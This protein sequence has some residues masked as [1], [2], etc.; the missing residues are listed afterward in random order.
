[1]TATTALSAIPSGLR[2]PLLKEYREI[3]Q[4]YS[5]HRWRP[6]ELSGGHFSE[7]V[8]TILDGH[9]SGTYAIG[10]SKPSDFVTACRKLETNKHVPRSF[11]ILIPRMLPA[12]YEV[13]NQRS[14]GHTGGDVDPNHMDA[15]LVI[16]MSNWIMA[17][18]VRVFHQLPTTEQAQIIVDTLAERTVPLVWQSGHLKR[19][20]DPKMKLPDQVMLLIASAPGPLLISQVM[21][22]C[23]AKTT[24]QRKHFMKTVRRLHAEKN[25][26][27]SDND[28]NIQILPPGSKRVSDFV[29]A[30]Q[31]I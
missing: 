26:N 29:A 21:E 5:E 19:V 24:D 18:L 15:T 6:S 17:E 1:M 14:V 27:L 13:R 8:Y 28:T 31:T 12:L 7:I 20:L 4:N 11:Q 9:A 25:L 30:R 2:D 16:G 22:W 23:E 3:T 10:P